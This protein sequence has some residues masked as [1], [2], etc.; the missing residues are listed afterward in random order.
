MS[1]TGLIAERQAKIAQRW[2]DKTI[3]TYPQD[4]SGFLARQ[5]NQFANPVGCT[6]SGS[7]EAIVPILCD[8]ASLEALRDELEPVIR[9]RAV[10][11]FSPAQA[12]SFI[13]LLKAAIR[14][15]LRAELADAELGR[16]L[17]HFEAR[18]DR[19]ALLG[20]EIYVECR[21][22]VCELRIDEMRRSVGL[23]WRKS[24]GDSDPPVSGL[25]DD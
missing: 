14:E 23:L 15:E 3:E 8:G 7:L 19:M 21:E 25:S 1:L 5:K 6:L 16:A 18:I 24:F 12:L 9:I 22:R 11:E 2:L 13:Y 10:Q 20:F 17:W 4:A